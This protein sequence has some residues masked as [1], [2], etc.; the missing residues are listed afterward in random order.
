MKEP[1]YLLFCLL[2]AVVWPAVICGA[3]ALAVPNLMAGK[4]APVATAAVAS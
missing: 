3:S 2:A 4:F 1:Q